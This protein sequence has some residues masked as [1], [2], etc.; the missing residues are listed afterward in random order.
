MTLLGS[1]CSLCW[2]GF[3]CCE[4]AVRFVKAVIAFMIGSVAVGLA[5]QAKHD[6]N[7]MMRMMTHHTGI[8]MFLSNMFTF[9]FAFMYLINVGAMIYTLLG[10]ACFRNCIFRERQNETTKCRA[11]Q[12]CL[13]PCCASYQ[14]GMVAISLVLQVVLSYCYLMMGVFLGMLLGM[15]HGGHAVVSSFQGF[16][17]EY[18]SRNSYQSGSFSPINFL[19][20]LDVAKYCDATRGMNQ[21][22]M[23]CFM[24]CALS[25]V[26]QS[27]M[28]MVIS[29]EKG[30]IEGTMADGAIVGIADKK[31]RRTSNSSSSSSSSSS[32]GET[33]IKDPLTQYRQHADLHA[34]RNYKVPG[35][36]D[37]RTYH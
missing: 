27:L 13:G 5:F 20:N 17:D 10:L 6:V 3:G 33:N 1:V 25:V 18:H 16:L 29:E 19:M 30:R 32:D 11:I 4:D 31:K 24:G 7:N 12:C 36:F 21:A 15:C 2:K 22:A 26:S 14:Q 34:G 35:G 9:G 37:G 23:Q 28:L 8:V